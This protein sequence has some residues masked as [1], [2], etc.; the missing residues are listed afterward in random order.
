MRDAYSLSSPGVNGLRRTLGFREIGSEER[1]VWKTKVA[2][3]LI[4]YSE[5]I[6]TSPD[7]V[8]I[9]S[10]DTLYHWMVRESKYS[11][12]SNFMIIPCSL[13]LLSNTASSIH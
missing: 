13:S 6:S 3:S 5:A 1:V 8:S 9:G 10:V 11:T 4:D 2:S 7:P 12:R